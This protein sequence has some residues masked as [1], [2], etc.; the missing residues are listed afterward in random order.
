MIISEN[1]T[2]FWQ[3]LI[4]KLPKSIRYKTAHFWII[5]GEDG[6]L[7]DGGG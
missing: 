6:D 4:V 7:E 2:Y 3:I 1:S 5:R